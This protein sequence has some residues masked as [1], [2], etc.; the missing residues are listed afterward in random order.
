MERP[1]AHMITLLSENLG[2]AEGWAR[3]AEALAEEMGLYTTDFARINRR[4]W[5]SSRDG[6][7]PRPCM[8]PCFR[9]PGSARY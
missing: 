2:Y 1:K 3:Y 5:F 7:G 8:R 6:T 4:L 9:R